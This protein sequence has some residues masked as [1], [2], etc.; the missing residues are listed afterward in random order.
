MF[1]ILEHMADIGFRA[2]AASLA[3]L[4]ESAAEALAG[5]A[6]ETGDIVPRESYSLAAQGD[7]VETLLVNWLSEVVYYIDGK[8]LAMGRF[9][10]RELDA[11]RVRG[12]AYGEPRD[13]VRHPARLIIKGVTYHQLKIGQQGHCWYCEVYLDI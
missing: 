1:E 3:G 10:V 6:M 9:K 5:I 2:Q 13:P 4:F 12:T 7:S 8:G 11:H